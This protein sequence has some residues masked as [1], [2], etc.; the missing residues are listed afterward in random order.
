MPALQFPL[1]PSIGFCLNPSMVGG[2]LIKSQGWV[3]VLTLGHE[4]STLSTSF[5]WMHFKDCP[6][7]TLA[8]LG[9]ICFLVC[10]LVVSPWSSGKVLLH[11]LPSQI[12]LC[13]SVG[14][15][16]YWSL[17]QLWGFQSWPRK[18][19]DH[20]MMVSTRSSTEWHLD[21]IAWEKSLRQE[22]FSETAAR[23][24]WPENKEDKRSSEGSSTWRGFMYLDD[25]VQQLGGESLGQN[26]LKSSR[27]LGF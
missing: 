27:S 16:F 25:A 22:N 23:G 6:P 19:Q 14:Y 2:L 5:R 26:V 11:V 17:W 9:R 7:S 24:H 10:S 12:N 20:E 3:E 15:V 13:S 21:R 1:Q 18:I 4:S 8:S